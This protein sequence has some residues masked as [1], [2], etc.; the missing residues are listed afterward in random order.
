MYFEMMEISLPAETREMMGWVA[1]ER[2]EM[3]P[4]ILDN[5]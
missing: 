2:S 1:L 3:V 5:F 4:S